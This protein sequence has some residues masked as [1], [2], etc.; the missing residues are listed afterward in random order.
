MLRRLDYYVSYFDESN[1]A[2]Y[3]KYKLFTFDNNAISKSSKS[4]TGSQ[5]KQSPQLHINIL[6]DYKNSVNLNTQN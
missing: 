2:L 3:K 4:N 6:H 1:Q 5:N